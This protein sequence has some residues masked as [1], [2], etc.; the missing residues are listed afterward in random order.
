M[1]E[2]TCEQQAICDIYLYGNYVANLPP[3]GLT[4][5]EIARIERATRG[6]SH[7][8]LWNILRLDRKTASNS[9]SAYTSNAWC[10]QA[11]TF[12]LDQE[13]TVKRNKT[14]V[15]LI[16][17]KLELQLGV[18]ILESVLDCGMFLSR[19]GLCAASPDAYFVTDSDVF[20]PVEIKCPLKYKDVTVDEMRNALN[21]RKPRYRV[22]HTA[23]SV[24]R[25]GPAVFSVESTDAHYRQM[26]RQMYVLDAPL[27]VYLVKFKDSFVV[28]FVDRDK[29]FYEQELHNE[30]RL[31]NTFLA[32]TQKQRRPDDAEKRIVSFCNQN[33]T[34]S[35]DEVRSLADDGFCYKYGRLV[36]VRCDMEIDGDIRCN[37]VLARHASSG[38]G[39]NDA[40][41]LN[42]VSHADYRD[43]SK[44]LE[45]L[46]K[47]CADL[48]LAEQG[49]FCNKNGQLMTF[50]CGLYVN[51]GT[52]V[53]HVDKCAYAKCL[54]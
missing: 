1:T 49:V 24:N 3:K 9:T 26:Q 53:K 4:V 17:H 16:K 6:Q 40:A 34:F 22:K 28:S 35:A 20:I 50:C 25:D 5:E 29:R 46:A 10:T 30:Q 39:D 2:L 33:H 15:N 38:C 12:G 44:R 37:D 45:S 7:N 14:L 11:M 41:T 21:V 27:C 54:K 31:F 52:E 13:R 32:Q 43:H 42:T 51:S 48:W 47:A 23:F 8:P 36:C 19:L 18:T